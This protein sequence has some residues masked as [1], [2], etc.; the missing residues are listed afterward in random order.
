MEDDQ[1]HRDNLQKIK[2]SAL[3]ILERLNSSDNVDV[4]NAMTEYTALVDRFYQDNE[5]LM[6]PE[7]YRAARQDFEY[8]LRLLDLALHYYSAASE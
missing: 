7:Q 8:F 3:S 2:L 5:N 1:N 4:Q 6:V